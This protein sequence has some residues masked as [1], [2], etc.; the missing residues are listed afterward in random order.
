LYFLELFLKA[1]GGFKGESYGVPQGDGT[2]NAPGKLESLTHIALKWGIRRESHVTLAILVT[3]LT[4][5]AA[6]IIPFL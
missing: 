4:L 3:Q 6:M 5:S 2:L 1:R